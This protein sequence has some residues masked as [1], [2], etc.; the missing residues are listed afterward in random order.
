MR[1]IIHLILIIIAGLIQVSLVNLF[2][3]QT[4][5]ILISVIFLSFLGIDKSFW[6][7]F[8]GGIF[9]DIYSLYPFGLFTLTL[10]IVAL[11]SHILSGRVFT[12]HT[13]LSMLATGIC[14]ILTF[15]IF[16]LAAN[17]ILFLLRI[18]NF[19]LVLNKMYW[20]NLFWQS[21]LGLLFLT[22]VFLSARFI[23]RRLRKIFIFKEKTIQV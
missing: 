12:N 15:K 23:S 4:N 14:G 6:W 17:Q 11:I 5:L 19:Y 3:V 16:L 10:L 21:A 22:L 2:K 1:F 20:I 8:F 18:T 13:F 7:A 9:L